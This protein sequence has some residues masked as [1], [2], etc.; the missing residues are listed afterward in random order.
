V[1]EKVGRLAYRLD[2]LPSMGIY[3]VVSVAHLIVTPNDKDPFHHTA[4]PPRTVEDSHSN[5]DGEASDLW[6]VEAVLDY[7][8][9]P[10]G[11]K[12]LIK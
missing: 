4:P 7:K 3:P 8:P 9:I 2:F 6:K 11:N 1:V 12:F 10:N 5:F